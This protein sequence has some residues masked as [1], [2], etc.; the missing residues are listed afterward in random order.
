MA[1]PERSSGHIGF[2]VDWPEQREFLQIGD[3][4]YVAFSNAVIMPNGRRTGRWECSRSH[5]DR[6]KA[7]GVFP[8]LDTDGEVK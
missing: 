3:D 6:Y 4:V 7:V 2:T 1:A 5:Y 8:R